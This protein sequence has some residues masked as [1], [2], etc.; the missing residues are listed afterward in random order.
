MADMITANPL[1]LK[2]DLWIVNA[3]LAVTCHYLSEKSRP[4]TVM[5]AVFK[6]ASTHTAKHIKEARNV[7]L[8]SWGI[9][10]KTPNRPRFQHDSVC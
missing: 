2:S 5:L 9:R 10:D 6:F 1:N 7:L 8:E 3:Y 4:P